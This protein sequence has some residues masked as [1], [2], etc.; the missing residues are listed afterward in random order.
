MTAHHGMPLADTAGENAE[1]QEPHPF[2]HMSATWPLLDSHGSA[3]ATATRG[4][5]KRTKLFSGLRWWLPEIFATVLSLASLI[6]LIVLVC[7]YRGHSI[8][9]VQLPISLTLNGLVA[10]LSTINRA[11]LMVPVGSV[12]SQEVW[13]W[14]SG[15]SN[16]STHQR[17]RLRDLETSDNP[18]RGAW[19]SLIFLLSPKKR[20]PTL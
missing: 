15:S 14:L 2:T 10:M 4:P 13:L 7:V 6:A 20:L 5:R 11:A 16:R 1:F 9:Q 12:L 8:E 18:S 19:S 3:L 17:S